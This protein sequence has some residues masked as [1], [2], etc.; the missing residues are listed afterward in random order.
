[1]HGVYNGAVVIGDSHRRAESH[2]SLDSTEPNTST[3]EIGNRSSGSTARSR[4]RA[5]CH[6][7]RHAMSHCKKRIQRATVT[8]A[9]PT[10]L[11]PN[12]MASAT[13]VAT[14]ASVAMNA[15]ELRPKNRTVGGK[16]RRRHQ[17]QHS[18]IRDSNNEVSS[19]ASPRTFRGK[20]ER[21]SGPS[22]LRRGHPRR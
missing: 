6:A 15:Y 20:S 7:S 8:H 19:T 4:P 13:V 2:A 21:C 18:P 12:A 10:N 11:A 14:A 1:M 22:Q 16:T 17:P 3:N 9:A 5:A